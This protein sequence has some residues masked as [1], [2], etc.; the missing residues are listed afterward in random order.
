MSKEKEVL[1]ILSNI[2]SSNWQQL[3]SSVKLFL[4]AFVLAN[5]DIGEEVNRIIYE[6]FLY[7]NLFE[8]VDDFYSKQEVPIHQNV[9]LNLILKKFWDSFNHATS[10]NDKSGKLLEA[11][12][13]MDL[14]DKISSK[15]KVDG[16]QKEDII[17]IKHLLKALSNMKNFRIFYDRKNTYSPSQ[18]TAK[19]GSIVDASGDGIVQ[20][21]LTLITLILEQN[22]K[23]YLA[24]EKLYK[25]LSDLTIYSSTSESI[26]ALSSAYFGKLL[27]ACIESALVD[28]NFEFA[29]KKSI[30]LFEYYSNDDHN[31]LISLW[32]TFYQVGKFVSPNWMDDA[33][34]TND[35]I[36]TLIKQREILSMTLRL[37]IPSETT[38]DNSK[39]IIKQWN[40]INN[41]IELWYT[42][43][44][45]NHLGSSSKESYLMSDVS[46]KFGASASSIIDDVTTT[47]NQANE[48]LSNLFVSGLGWAIGAN[49]K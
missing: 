39:L 19:F 33:D 18:I 46:E 17:R 29:Y 42:Q 22:P 44:Q 6:R 38:I 8:V 15:G 49:Q 35:R 28:N 12:Q 23:S 20:S 9:I 31:M 25:I 16:L 5:D 7:A 30:E 34:I 10:L 36:E 40:H 2:T 21:P 14:L 47:T 48:K 11:T 37:P 26:D 13:S 32:L 27:A 4:G 45:S 41:Q 3:F 43:L 1:R 24:Y